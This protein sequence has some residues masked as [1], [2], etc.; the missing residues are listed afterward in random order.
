MGFLFLVLVSFFSFSFLLDVVEVAALDCLLKRL[1]GKLLLS[2][3]EVVL[4][5]SDRAGSSES[6]SLD[7][8]D[9]SAEAAL[10]ERVKILDNRRRVDSRCDFG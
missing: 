10:G 5:V 2:D 8:S 7:V 3:D 9:V 1:L 4:D 6:R